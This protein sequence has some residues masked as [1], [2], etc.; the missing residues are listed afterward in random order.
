[1]SESKVTFAEL[2]PDSGERFQRLRRDLGVQSFGINLLVLEPGQ[3]SRVHVHERQ[4]EV[5]LVLAGELTLIVEDDEH[6]LGRGRLARVPGAVRRQ[7]VNR[8]DARVEL[9]ALGG[10]GEHDPRDALAWESWEEQGPGRSPADVSLPD[11]LS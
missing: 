2:D 4:E 1:M 5:Y 3:R 11:D 8:S 6:V 9:I 7:L 10:A